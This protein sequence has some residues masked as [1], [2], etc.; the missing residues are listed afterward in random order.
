MHI[1]QH[2]SP[3]F[4]NR[5]DGKK[6]QIQHLILHYTDTKHCKEALEIMC[7]PKK[8]V[9]AHYCADVDGTIYQLVN[10]ENRAWHAGLSH[11]DGIDGLN[12]SSI[13]IEIQNP[14]HS[15]GYVPFPK[16][17]IEAVMK[18]CQ[19][20]IARHNIP[21]HYVLAHSDI[22]P[23]RKQ[24][25]GHLFP[26]QQLAEAG[27]GHFPATSTAPP[28]SAQQLIT[29]GYQ[30]ADKDSIT[31]FQRRF[32]P[33]RLGQEWSAKEGHMLAALLALKG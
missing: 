14:G 11:W 27:I 9:S 5:P 31:A 3:N 10:E 28:A 30:T 26:W 25:P 32:L 16:T 1:T 19:G 2:S 21:A 7:D 4:N 17:Q 18:L 29:Y 20:I 24:D 13:G 6:G 22:A 23:Q 15:H 12:D 8:E 33:E